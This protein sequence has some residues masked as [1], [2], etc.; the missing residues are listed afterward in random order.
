VHPKFQ[1]VVQ[2]IVCTRSIDADL[3]L[4]DPN[5]PPRY[6]REKLRAEL[7]AHADKI[8]ALQRAE[9]KTSNPT[10]VEQFRAQ[11]KQEKSAMRR[12]EKRI[13]IR[14]SKFQNLK[15]EENYVKHESGEPARYKR[16]SILNDISVLQRSKQAAPPKPAPV[17]KPARVQETVTPTEVLT[18]FEQRFPRLFGKVEAGK[19]KHKKPAAAEPPKKKQNVGP[20]LPAVGNGKHKDFY[21]LRETWETSTNRTQFGSKTTA[22]QPP[23]SVASP[24]AASLADGG[25]SS[26]DSDGEY[27]TD[28]DDDDGKAAGGGKHSKLVKTAQQQHQEQQEH[29]K[30]E[31]KAIAGKEYLQ[32]C[33]RLQ[34]L[35]EPLALADRAHDGVL[36]L[37]HYALTQKKLDTLEPAFKHLPKARVLNLKGNRLHDGHL[38]GSRAALGGG[39]SKEQQQRLQREGGPPLGEV[40]DGKLEDSEDE[41]ESKL[42]RIS[43]KRSKSGA[44]GRL[45]EALGDTV[46]TLILDNNCIGLQGVRQLCRVFSRESC[47][48]TAI[49]MSRQGAPG[50]ASASSASSRGLCARSIVLLCEGLGALNQ[51]RGQLKALNLSENLLVAAGQHQEGDGGEEEKGEAASGG[52]G[53]LGAIARLVEGD[54]GRR[55]TSLNLSGCGIRGG[56]SSAALFQGLLQCAKKGVGIVQLDLSEN[57]FGSRW[58]GEIALLNAT[59]L[60]GVALPTAA[61]T[62][63]SE[64]KVGGMGKALEDEEDSEEQMLLGD[65]G[66]LASYLSQDDRLRRLNLSN[67]RIG[68]TDVAILGKALCSNHTLLGLR[69]DGNEGTV[70]AKG[71]LCPFGEDGSGGSQPQCVH[72]WMCQLLTTANANSVPKPIP[73]EEGANDD[74]NAQA[75]PPAPAAPPGETKDGVSYSVLLD[76]HRKFRV[77]AGLVAKAN[78]VCDPRYFKGEWRFLLDFGRSRAERVGYSL[79]VTHCV[80]VFA[81]TR[82]AASNNGDIKHDDDDKIHCG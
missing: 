62:D 19:K 44:L 74:D 8:R 51:G 21:E 18:R 30:Q 54:G 46:E 15:P 17:A 41:D 31:Q 59:A 39:G 23:A 49:T 27:W 47:M 48:L 32:S 22:H 2:H 67:N 38:S 68:R 56:A 71:F 66:W 33:Q 40:G 11:I 64:G 26:E 76:P 5:L 79:H 24:S 16:M 61:D 65:V 77:G 7:D 42:A 4:P 55:L 20:R 52:G 75:A 50:A 14:V 69:F 36:D 28:D 45:F 43:S 37:S 29:L 34:M 57:N 10:V 35:A 72:E 70:D 58:S 73:L 9:M 1:V 13:G 63:E 3:G 53:A 6:I 78:Q 82:I 80:A 81:G 25:D 60:E 12:K